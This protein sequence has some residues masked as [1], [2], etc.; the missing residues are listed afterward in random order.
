MLGYGAAGVALWVGGA[1]IEPP[2][3]RAFAAMVGTSVMLGAAFLAIGYLA[4][5]LVRDRA[6][7][8]GMALGIWLVLGDGLRHRAARPAGGRPGRYVTPGGCTA[9]LLLNPA[10]AYRLFNLTGFKNVGLFAGTAGLAGQVQF[11]AP[12][13]AGR[14]G[15]LDRRA[16]WRW[17]PSS[18]QGEQI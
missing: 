3:W 8:A 6:T 18:S 12:A 1:P 15:R 9:L 7:A 14:A 2:S 4:S 11:G 10:D 16:R 13:P 5:T 17:P